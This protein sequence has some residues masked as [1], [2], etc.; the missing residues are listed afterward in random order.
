[1]ATVIC[2]FECSWFDSLYVVKYI[3]IGKC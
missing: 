1:L 3:G 2:Y